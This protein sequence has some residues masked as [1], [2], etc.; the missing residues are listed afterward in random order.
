MKPLLDQR[1]VVVV[2]ALRHLGLRC[3]R[4]GLRL[5]LAYARLVVAGVDARH[6]LASLDGVAFAHRQAT[7]FAGDL[8]LDH[9]GFGC[10]QRS[11]DRQGLRH[12]DA[13]HLQQVG[14]K[15]RHRRL[16]DD[17]SP[18]W[19]CLRVAQFD[20]TQHGA[21]EQQQRQC[22]G[23][24]CNP[25]LHGSLR[26]ARLSWRLRRSSWVVSPAPSGRQPGGRSTKF[27]AVQPLLACHTS[28][29]SRAQ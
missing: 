2:A 14:S 21:G 24:P 10:A 28:R 19:R 29:S 22:H 3:G 11:G 13:G 25:S 5:C 18:R 8:C 7:D 6:D 20:A 23:G 9:G 16:G 26:M 1:L 27:K 17:R 12:V 4:F 15:Q